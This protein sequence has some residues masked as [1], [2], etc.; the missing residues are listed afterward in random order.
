MLTSINRMCRKHGQSFLALTME[1]LRDT[2]AALPERLTNG[3]QEQGMGAGTTNSSATL[4][5]LDHNLH[6]LARR[7]AQAN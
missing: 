2:T 5:E 7:A 4:E 6:K 1:R 3:G